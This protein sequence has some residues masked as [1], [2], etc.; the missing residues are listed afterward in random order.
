MIYAIDRDFSDAQWQALNGNATAMAAILRDSNRTLDAG[1]RDA[2]AMMIERLA[3]HARGDIGGKVGRREKDAGHPEVRRVVER[4]DD[5][6]AQGRQHTEAKK[7]VQ[8]EQNIKSIRTVEKYIRLR[9]QRDKA[10]AQF[11]RG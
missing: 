3:E 8:A 6:I 7:L 2:L 4:Y 11:E 9:R 10:I 5:L 1:E